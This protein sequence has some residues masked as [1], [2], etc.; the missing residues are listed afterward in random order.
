MDVALS[1]ARGRR[2]T[3]LAGVRA[4]WRERRPPPSARPAPGRRLHGGDRGA[5]SS[6]RWR[7][8][9]R[10]RR[11]AQVV[12][13]R[14]GSPRTGPSLALARAAARPR[15]GAPIRARWC[16]RSPDVAFL[17]GA[18]LRRSVLAA[19]PLRARPGRRRAGRR[20]RRRRWRVVG[21]A[22]EGRGDRRGAARPGSWPA[23]AAARG[24]SASPAPGAC[25][26]RRAGRGR[27]ASR[28]PRSAG[29]RRRA[30][31]RGQRRAPTGRAGRAVVGA[32]GL[33][34]CS[35]CPGTDR[36]VAA[37][38]RAAGGRDR[39]SPSRPPP[40]A[41]S[42]ARPSATPSAPRRA[43]EPMASAWGLDARTARLSLR[44][45]A[46]PA[47]RR[48]HAACVRRA[49]PSSRSRGATRRRALRAPQRTLGSAALAGGAAA[50]AI[51]GRRPPGGRGPWPPWAATS[52]RAPCSSRCAWRSTG[53]APRACFCAV[54]SAASCSATSPYRSP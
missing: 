36:G 35:P 1:A 29:P 18:P 9:R 7:T 49:T 26:A 13:A 3:R 43:A 19:R 48:P 11:S 40:A 32:V 42:T 16:S 17:L 10:A 15:A 5:R 8:A 33:G 4:W 23:C 50:V 21:L 24:R 6:A 52:R 41:S 28:C 22:G 51:A 27:S 47:R 14:R 39:A 44:R 20:G 45:A 25:S 53:R 12:D 54:P 37:R 38:A 34:A 46:G 30:R 2:R 31:R